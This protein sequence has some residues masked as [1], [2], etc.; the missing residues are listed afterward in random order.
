MRQIIFTGILFLFTATMLKAQQGP[1][2]AGW[3]SVFNSYRIQDSKFSIHLDA[4]A[5]SGDRWESFQT[6]IVRPGINYHVRK[7]MILTAGYAMVSNRYQQ[8]EHFTEHR[9]WEQFIISHPVAF[10]PL[11]HR[12]RVEQRFIGNMVYDAAETKWD[13][14]GHNTAHR[15]RYFLRGVIPFSGE[16]SFSKGMFGA[17]QNEVFLNF[18]DKS[19]VNGQTFDQN[20]AYVAVGYR[21]SARFDLEAG[22]LN[23][24]IDQRNDNFSNV[25]VAQIAGYLRL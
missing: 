5:R 2:F 18:G 1:Q 23:Q 4:T 25:H 13:K 11:Q 21:F 22:Y 14:D 24:Y 15:F 3:L 20:R 16:R 12:F 17:V 10:F 19:A 9:I 8:T 6:F 7:N